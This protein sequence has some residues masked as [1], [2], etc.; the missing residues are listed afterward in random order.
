MMITSISFINDIY[1]AFAKRVN[2]AVKL[3]GEEKAREKERE[4][5][6]ERERERERENIESRH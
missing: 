2:Y 3:E 5:K 6:R 1:D 4:R